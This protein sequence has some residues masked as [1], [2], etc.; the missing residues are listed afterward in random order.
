MVRLSPRLCRA[1][2][3]MLGWQQEDLAAAA[4]VSKSTIGAFETRQEDARLMGQNNR[5]LTEAFEHAGLCF[6]P[7]NGGGAGV[8]W[9]SRA[10]RA[11]I[12]HPK[13]AGPATEAVDT[14]DQAIEKDR[15]GKRRRDDG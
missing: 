3:S 5:A 1:A 6:I 12:D 2:R 7:E 13:P 14:M 11:T 4:G 8:R 15:S 9:R 10:D